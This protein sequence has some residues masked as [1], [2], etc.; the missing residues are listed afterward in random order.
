MKEVTRTLIFVGVA[1]VSVTVA[2]VTHFAARPKPSG[3]DARIGTEFYPDFQDPTAATAL[4]LAAY[5]EA[6][7]T[8]RDFSVKLDGGR[9]VIPS[10]HNYPADAKD[11]LKKTATSV[12]GITRDA[13]ASRFKNAHEEFGVIDPKDQATETLEGRGQ[14][15]RILGEGDKVLAD[16]IIGKKVEGQTDAYYVRLPNEKETYIA[17]LKIDLS[18][19]FADWIEADLLK[20][21][22]D[23][24]IRL[25]IDKYAV[26]EEEIAEN[27]L[28]YLMRVIDTATREKSTLTR[29]E[30]SDPW[31]LE[32]LDEEAYE[33]DKDKV[34]ELVND[35]DDLKIIGV[36]PK[37]PGI[38]A[39]LTLDPQYVRN[40]LQRDILQQELASKG[41]FVLADPDQPV[42]PDSGRPRPR[43]AARNG[44]LIAATK[45]GVVY[46]LRFGELFT[47]S[48][49]DVE[50]GFA[51]DSQKEQKPEAQ[52]GQTD[53]N[54]EG[55]Q[56]KK[57]DSGNE[58][59]SDD[60]QPRADKSDSD[61]STSSSDKKT[62]SK[63]SRYLFVSVAFDES[64]I[65]D[66]PVQPTEPPPAAAPADAPQDKPAAE[67]SPAEKPD[68]D[69]EEASE[70][71][72]SEDNKAAPESKE[73]TA[74]KSESDQPKSDESGKPADE[75]DDK[76]K[77]AQEQYK[78]DVEKYQQD[79]KAYETKVSDGKKKAAELAERFAG[80]YY[81]ISG[82]SFENLRLSRAELIKP[83][84]AE[85]SSSKP[86]ATTPD[87]DAPAE[88]RKPADAVPEST[89]E[90][91]QK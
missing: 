87:A 70:E 23:D 32:G 25:V 42:D 33:V 41:F 47:G 91:R 72:Q 17:R 50:V 21:D 14:R 71:K 6:T 15:L 85:D 65:P 62:D 76:L 8:V 63:K 61:N 43:L 44:E 83:K 66:K 20:F 90:P 46:T 30:W 53:E 60:E 11:R 75:A 81:V 67:K 22:R 77:Q 28:V 68:D 24:L 12:I 79:L 34:R 88:A 59:K 69:D 51:T 19:R 64:L 2:A 86:A 78:K 16:F 80:W 1:C 39:D 3:V 82:E 7:A 58:P 36:R 13:L 27:G 18:T 56:E 35:L 55:A 89:I 10:H 52:D 5:D 26:K 73:P 4:E 40:K 37:P 74:G 57:P 48:E 38:N 29:K 31:K 9:W 45:A 84:Q 54:Q 49:L